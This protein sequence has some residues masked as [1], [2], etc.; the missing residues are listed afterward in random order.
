[1]ESTI[2]I[3]LEDN[4]QDFTHLE[5]R[6]D[7]KIINS[8]PCQGYIWSKYKISQLHNLKVGEYPRLTLNRW[9]GFLH[10]RVKAITKNCSWEKY[11]AIKAL[12][13]LTKQRQETF[14]GKKGGKSVG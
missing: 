11:C 7:G 8:Y 3:E 9:N 13:P 5:V 2:I 14:T 1:M 4:A 6:N 12:E 10:H